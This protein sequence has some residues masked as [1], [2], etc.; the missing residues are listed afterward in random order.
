MR[1]AGK[2][3]E[4]AFFD[5]IGLMSQ[6]W[7]ERPPYYA[8]VLDSYSGYSMEC[9]I[10]CKSKAVNAVI[11]MTRRYVNRKVCSRNG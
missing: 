5:V 2:P 8:T 7:I 1:G 11:Q 10:A 9:F 6:H 3:L 4:K